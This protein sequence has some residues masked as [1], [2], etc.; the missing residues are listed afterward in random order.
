[1]SKKNKATPHQSVWVRDKGTPI[2]IFTDG[3]VKDDMKPMGHQR[4]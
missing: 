2:D 1:M 3:P 4:Q